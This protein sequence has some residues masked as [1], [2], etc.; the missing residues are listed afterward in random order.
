MKIL[1]F[2]FYIFYILLKYCYI[3]FTLNTFILSLNVFQYVSFVMGAE[4]KL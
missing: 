2:I 1:L 3:F 4:L